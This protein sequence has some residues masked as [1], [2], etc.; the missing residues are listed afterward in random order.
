[1][2]KVVDP[3]SC[4]YVELTFNGQTRV[5]EFPPDDER[6]FVVGS[7]DHASLRMNGDGIAPVQFHLERED[8]AI[9]LIPAYGVDDLSVDWFRVLGPTPLDVKSVIEFCA[10]RIHVTIAEADCLATDDDRLIVQRPDAQLSGKSYARSL[11]GEED[12]T[13]LAMP[14][15]RASE[16]VVAPAHAEQRRTPPEIVIPG[17][18]SI[19]PRWSLSDDESTPCNV[20]PETAVQRVSG[21]V[22][23]RA[24]QSRAGAWSKPTRLLLIGGACVGAVVFVVALCIVARLFQLHQHA[25]AHDAPKAVDSR[26]P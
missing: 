17:R 13:L 8:G 15:V 4:V 20:R 3:N 6:A 5:Q 23:R 21:T 1:M 14:A 25:D 11:P 26:S 9:W 12:P 16:P 7:A 2:F 10:A 18:P 24:R 19:E 22:G